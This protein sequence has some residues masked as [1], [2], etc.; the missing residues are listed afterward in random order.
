MNAKLYHTQEPLG[1]ELLVA[2]AMVKVTPSLRF[3][4]FRLAAEL[5]AREHPKEK[6]VS[7]VIEVENKINELQSVCEAAGIE[8][9]VEP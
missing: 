5:F 2:L 9:S 8:V 4:S 6:P 1:R 3:E 7:I